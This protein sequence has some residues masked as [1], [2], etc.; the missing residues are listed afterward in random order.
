MPER[1]TGERGGG[2]LIEC[3]EVHPLSILGPHMKQVD[4]PYDTELNDSLSPG[5]RNRATSYPFAVS[6]SVK[7]IIEALGVP[8]TEIDLILTNGESVDF[9]YHVQRCDGGL[10]STRSHQF[11]VSPNRM[12]RLDSGGGVRT[13]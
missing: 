2:F 10:L 6:T 13:L 5:R 3:V 11:S 1:D 8:H 7:D 9:S 4:V 12:L